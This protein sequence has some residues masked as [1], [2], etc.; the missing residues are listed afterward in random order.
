MKTTKMLAILVLALPLLVCQATVS[1]AAEIGTA[2][3]YQGRLIDANEPADGLYDFQFELYNDPCT[4]TQQG[5]TIDVNELDV[6]DGYFTV[7]LDFG[8]VF[9]GDRRWLEIG[10]RPGELED[11]NEYTTLSPR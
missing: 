5:G 6:I 11:P 9:D 10:V 1:K 7:E 2:F 8:S 3:T 4:G